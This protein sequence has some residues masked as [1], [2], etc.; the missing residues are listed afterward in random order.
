MEVAKG[1][2]YPKEVEIVDNVPICPGFVAVRIDM[3]HEDFM[4]LELEV[5]PDDLTRTLRDT[6]Q[7]TKVHWRRS[8]IIV[9]SAASWTPPPSPT[10]M[11]HP[12]YYMTRSR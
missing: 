10:V 5:Q 6:Q 2:V 4:E 12:K 7:Y 3:V 9:E 11:D 8:L 1:V